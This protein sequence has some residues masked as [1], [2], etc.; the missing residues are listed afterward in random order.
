MRILQQKFLLV[1]LH[2]ALLMISP[3]AFANMK[4][5]IEAYNKGNIS[6]ALHLSNHH[7]YKA[8]HS[9]IYSQKLLQKTDSSSFEEI[10]S[11]L[12]AHP[13]WPQF[14]S[15]ALVAENRI[16]SSTSKTKI[17]KWFEHHKPLTPSGYYNYYVAAEARLKPSEKLNAIIKSAWIHGSFTKPQ[18]ESFLK[19][20]KR[21]LTQDDFADRIA[22]LLWAGKT[23]EA[24]SYFS[25]VDNNYKQMFHAWIALGSKT[26]EREFHKVKGSYRYHSGL[27]YNY[28]KLHMKTP[29]NPELIALHIKAPKDEKH[30]KEWWKLKNYIARELLETRQYKQA[31]AIV[32][33]HALTDACDSTEAEWFA[34]WL[35]LRYLKKPQDAIKHFENLYASSKSSISLSRGAYWLGRSYKALGKNESAKTWFETAADYGY[36]FYGQLAQFE[37][38]NKNLTLAT[39]PI[40]NPQDRLDYKSNKMAQIAEF[41][42]GTK[43]TELIKLYSKEAFY[44]SKS[45]GEVALIYDKVTPNLSFTMKV[46]IAKLAQHS[47]VLLLN[48]AYP[49]PFKAAKESTDPALTFSII[50]QESVFDQY[51]VSEANAQGLMQVL[52]KTAPHLCK[53]IGIKYSLEKLTADPN[54]NIRLGTLYLDNVIKQYNHSYVMIAINYNAGPVVDKW[55]ARFGVRKSMKLYESIDWIESIPYQESRTYVQRVL[56]NL[57][58]YRY[59]LNKDTKLRIK[60]DVMR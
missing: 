49:A 22:E 36:T 9:F 27:L 31:Y 50:R 13:D 57:Q 15:L 20:H 10:T 4:E 44:N 18:A 6:G 29:P 1:T 38:G 41:L 7:K 3:S 40:V 14:K 58:V 52:P 59:V 33:N 46:E 45:A 60:N 21:I 54:Y 51:A 17:I 28:L 37:L 47:G 35:A 2:L 11:F 16:K 30:A 5:V 8:V 24:Q 26:S 55:E 19:K 34:G 23:T 43:Q 39:R 12:T 25:F 56:S 48:E 32:S 42:A 53:Q